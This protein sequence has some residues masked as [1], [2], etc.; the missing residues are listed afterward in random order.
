LLRSQIRMV[1]YTVF[2]L[3]LPSTSIPTPD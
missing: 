3:W 2:G 1:G